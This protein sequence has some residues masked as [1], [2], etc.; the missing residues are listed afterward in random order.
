VKKLD[1][2][3]PRPRNP[4]NSEGDFLELRDGRLL[5]AYSRF[6]G[7]SEDHSKAEIAARFSRDGGKTWTRRDR[8]LI[9][10]E[11]DMNVMS[12][13]LLRMAD[14]EVGLFYGRKNALD[15]CRIWLRR[16]RDEA[17]SF[18]PPV[19]CIP[20]PGYFVL[21]ND[22]VVRL[23]SGRLVVPTARH[24]VPGGR[25]TARGVASCYLSDDDGRTWRRSRS[26]LEGPTKA[27]CGL[28]EPLVVELKGGRLMMLCRTDLGCQFRS[29]SKD[30][31]ETWSRPTRTSILSPVSPASV[32]RIPSTGDLLM[33]WNET[34]TGRRTPLTVA[35]SRDEGKTW[36]EALT[37]EDDP[38]G[39]FC[40]TAIHFSGD[41]VLLA[42]CAGN[43]EIGLLNR[44]R[45]TTV[46]LSELYP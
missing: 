15:D 4:R 30:G 38:G 33:V 7:G 27:R 24:N 26:E 34:A 43:E 8:I 19:L 11:G 42:Y 28:Q 10:G 1:L 23:S 22:R 40:Y 16:S 2:L 9:T 45:M 41:R 46:R 35:L 36:R 17:K 14:G 31:G 6:T 21:N 20:D 44:L 5:F 25:W 3:P 18:G 29:T 13:S 39:W 37:V 32:A 12:V